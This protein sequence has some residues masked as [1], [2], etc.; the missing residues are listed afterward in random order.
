MRLDSP[1]R[2]I[3]TAL[4]ETVGEPRRGWAGAGSKSVPVWKAPLTSVNNGLP[5][6]SP[7]SRNGAQGCKRHVTLVSAGFG[8]SGRK[9]KLR[10]S[11][12]QKETR[13]VVKPVRDKLEARCMVLLK[14]QISGASR[15]M[16]T[17]TRGG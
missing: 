5:T 3:W 17:A 7:K 14:V 11:V 12:V 10:W 15:G 1:W 13:L 2:S 8:D 9:T 4:F 6:R 16:S